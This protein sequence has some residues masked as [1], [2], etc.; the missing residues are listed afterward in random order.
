MAPALLTVF[1]AFC[2]GTSLGFPISPFLFSPL[3]SSPPPLS[4]FLSFAAVA[5]KPRVSLCSRH[6][7]TPIEVH[8]NRSY[9]AACNKAPSIYSAESLCA[10]HPKWMKASYAGGSFKINTTS[11]SGWGKGKAL[12]NWST[13]CLPWILKCLYA[14]VCFGLPLCVCVLFFFFLQAREF[15]N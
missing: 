5:W 11:G 14:H 1:S 8:R 9:A 10:L 13:V 6:Q 2:S 3:S 7:V 4:L 12:N 15:L